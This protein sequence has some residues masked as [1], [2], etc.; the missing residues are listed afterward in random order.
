MSR[1]IESLYADCE[2]SL[3]RAGTALL[4]PLRGSTLL[5]TGGTGFTGLW[6]G[7]FAAFLN[8]RH[9]FGIEIV[10]TA[11]RV[12]RLA[13]QAPFLNG[14]ADYRFIPGDIRQFID[15]PANV[16]WIVHA[17][18]VPDSRH[19]ASNPLDTLSVI[20]NGTDR[21]LRLAENMVRLRAIL[22]F[23]SA[24][25]NGRQSLS[26]ALKEDQMGP[27][28]PLDVS[29]CYAEAKRYGEAVCSAYRSQM[30]L[31]II[32]TRPFTF[33][34]PFQ[35]LDAPWAVNNFLHS[36]LL[37]QPIRILG[38]GDTKRSFLYGSDMALLALQQLVAGQV[39]SVYNLGHADPI[40]LR[41][42]AQLIVLQS[43]RAMKITYNAAGRDVGTSLLVPDMQKSIQEFSFVPAFSVA[44]SVTRTLRWNEGG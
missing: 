44:E 28:D 4:E 34:G 11:R 1:Y 30:R 24:L 41:E 18:G 17:A 5:V 7:V 26:A 31:P 25:V 21:V 29:N 19:H 16:S 32:I 3:L 15:I 12:A 22:H 14:R 13:E 9:N 6:L 36:A 35:A 43:G 8:D 42:L 20:A 2:R 27:L 38:S 10:T 33:I 23:S 37:G 39:G 40:S